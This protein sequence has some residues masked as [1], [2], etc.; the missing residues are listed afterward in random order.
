MCLLVV[1]WHCHERYPLVVVANRDE[2]HD[3]PAAPAHWWADR[4]GLLA[5]RDLQAGGTWLGIA[6]DGRWAALTNY[7]EGVPEPGARSR[8]ELVRD[9]LG[10]AWQ[11][12]AYLAEVAGRAH[13]YGGFSLLVGDARR[14]CCYSNREGSVR[15]VEPGVHTLSNHLLDTPW[16]KARHARARMEEVLALPELSLGELFAVLA[17][18]E[19]FPDH[20]LPSTGIEPELERALSAPFIVGRHYGTR[21]TTVI[22]VDRD[23]AVLFAEQTYLP[24]GRPGPRVEERF[25]LDP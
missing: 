12:E 25:R 7:R 20:E 18:R 2:Y 24:E 1:A 19:P 6:R 4:P 16:P 5:G 3:R 10:G 8:G 11:P 17:R 15:P 23:G 22:R 9:Y 21:C 13:Q 14:L